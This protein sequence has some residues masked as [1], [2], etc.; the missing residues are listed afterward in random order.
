[1]AGA[2]GGAGAGA[3]TGALIEAEAGAGAEARAGSWDSCRSSSETS[4]RELEREECR[5]KAATRYVGSVGST[6]PSE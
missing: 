1:M 2:G 5:G 3:G 4:G 6:S